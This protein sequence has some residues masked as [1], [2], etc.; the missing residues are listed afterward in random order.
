MKVYLLINCK[1]GQTD[2][3][4]KY[5]KESVPGSTVNKVFGAF[6]ILMTIHDESMDSIRE[7]VI[8]KVRKHEAIESTMSL[9]GVNPDMK[10]EAS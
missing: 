7:T 5:L 9:I 1:L 2:T 10:V 8:W 4:I 3:V 6:D